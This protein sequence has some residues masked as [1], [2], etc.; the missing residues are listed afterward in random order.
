MPGPR[1]S[2]RWPATCLCRTEPVPNRIVDRRLKMEVAQM[3]KWT[4]G[5]LALAGSA[6]VFAPGVMAQSEWGDDD[7]DWVW[8][9]FDT[10]TYYTPPTVGMVAPPATVA[11]APQPGISYFSPPVGAGSSHSAGNFVL[12]PPVA[13]PVP[14]APAV[15][16]LVGRHILLLVRHWVA[17]WIRAGRSYTSVARRRQ[18]VAPPRLPLGC[19]KASCL[20]KAS[21]IIAQSMPTARQRRQL[22]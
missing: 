13:A 2:G 12:Q 9:E 22:P 6:F 1:A 17:A 19:V 5:L 15:S 11:P 4:M 10:E 18:D 16:G 8:N 3:R 21:A 7:A 14:E 20:V